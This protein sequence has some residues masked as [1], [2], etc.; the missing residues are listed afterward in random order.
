METKLLADTMLGRLARWLRIMGYDIHFQSS[1]PEGAMHALI[2]E[3]RRP[4]SR[5]QGLQRLFPDVLI[6]HSNRV[7]NQVHEAVQGLGLVPDRSRWFTR[8]LVC[9]VPLTEAGF[10]E[11]LENVPDYVLYENPSGIRHCACCSRYFWPGTHREKMLRKLEE[12]GF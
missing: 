10:E 4:L 11:R 1:Y 5:G 12:W 7:E 6:I 9:N 3:G 8:C 2:Q